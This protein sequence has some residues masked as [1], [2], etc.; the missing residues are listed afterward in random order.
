MRK[1]SI[2]KTSVG[3]LTCAALAVF[4]AG[5]VRAQGEA[6]APAAGGMKFYQTEV[7]Y[8][9]VGVD[10]AVNGIPVESDAAGSAG[11]GGELLNLFLLDEPNTITITLRPDKGAAARGLGAFA[12]V[13]VNAYGEARASKLERVYHFEWRQ[14]KIPRAMPGVVTGKLPPVKRARPLSWQGAPGVTVDAGARAAIAALIGRYHDALAAKDLPRLRALLATSTQDAA[15]ALGRSVPD[16]E[17]SQGRRFAEDFRSQTWRM[18]PVDYPHLRYRACAGGRLISVENPD[19]SAPLSSAPDKDGSTS[20][21]NT[22][23][24]FLNGQWTLL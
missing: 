9:A 21:F 2:K 22:R 15:L 10:I 18:K 7:H 20:Q 23:V 4:G 24:A 12:V 6:V 14:T 8:A 13:N 1:A 17:A 5:G 19:G 16:T 3:A 11:G